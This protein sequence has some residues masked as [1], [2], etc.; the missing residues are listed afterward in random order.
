MQAIAN[1]ANTPKVES[2][3]ADE[4]ARTLRDGFTAA[5]LA[6]AKKAIR[7]Q[8]VGGRSSDAGVL[9]LMATR[10]QW[11]R[12]LAWDEQLD[13]KLDGVTLEQVNAA[14]RKYVTPA[15]LTIVKGG[16]FK[17]A[18]VYRTR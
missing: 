3:F 16:D 18:N 7:D 11:G 6:D 14:F 17:A 4:L 15:S 12:T 8:R 1:P 13:A 5:E 9:N 2:S 10:E